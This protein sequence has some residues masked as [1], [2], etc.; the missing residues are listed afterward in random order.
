M[1]TYRV[2]TTARP[3]RVWTLLA[4]PERWSH[5]APHIRR[6][7]GLGTPEVELGARGQVRLAGLLPVA[8]RITAKVPG[9]SWTWQIGS[10]CMEHR[11]E[12]DGDGS[13]ITVEVTAPE[14]MEKAVA[15]TYGAA[16]SLLLRNLA[17]VAAPARKQASRTADPPLTPAP[18]SPPAA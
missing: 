1:L 5:W 9:R 12:P 14:A 4:R 17:R 6:A 18:V 8:A 10:I 11:V 16:M 15:L 2:R 3:E 13:L 7:T